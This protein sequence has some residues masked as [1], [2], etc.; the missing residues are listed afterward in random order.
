MPTSYRVTWFLRVL[1]VAP[2]LAGCPCFDTAGA[3]AS[4]QADSGL[5]LVTGSKTAGDARV[6]RIRVLA[7]DR[8]VVVLL[9]A[10]ARDA[11]LE[12]DGIVRQQAGGGASVGVGPLGHAAPTL[13]LA[14]LRPHDRVS[15]TVRGSN[16]SLRFADGSVVGLA[17]DVGIASGAY[18]AVLATLAI[19]QIVAFF[20][21][22]DP[23]IGWYL[24][25]T[26]SLL[27]LEFARN[28]ALPRGLDLPA[29]LALRASFMLCILGLSTTYLKLRSAAP[30]LFTVA[31]AV[32][33]VPSIFIAIDAL[34]TGVAAS[35]VALSVIDLAG[36]MTLFAA[37]IIRR[38]QGYASATYLGIGLLGLPLVLLATIAAKLAGIAAPALNQWGFEAGSSFD[39]FAFSIAILMRFQF[40]AVERD[41]IR[42]VLHS[43]TYD[44]NHDS[45]TGL[46]NRRGLQVR[47]SALSSIDSTVLF[48]DLDGFKA[49]N[50]AGGH[51]AGD[52]VL[53]A[54]GHILCECVRLP[55]IVARVGGDEF[56]VVLVDFLDPASVND[57]I[58]RISDKIARYRPLGENPI[59]IGASVGRAATNSGSPDAA[60]AAADRDAYRVKA[61]H[62]ATRQP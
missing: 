57:V 38:R 49:I 27:G 42:H 51:A 25:F 17:R 7:N 55:D 12:I 56:V 36:I 10:D 43:A 46:F 29:Q 26:L 48:V 1:V 13:T 62:H 33:V 58:G 28:D 54:V 3:G 39:V 19:V 23:V 32:I 44:A 20:V 5:A 9:P 60:I 34:V 24:G 22:R 8:T 37:A 53:K 47:M 11:T 6:Y 59:R 41:R 15:I 4:P 21:L 45:L 14:G 35:I 50:D 52:E 2:L 31:A 61:E 16:A 40:D 18:Y 30:R